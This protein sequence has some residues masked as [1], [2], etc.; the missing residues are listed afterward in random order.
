L[1]KM[2]ER[3]GEDYIILVRLHVIVKNT[4]KISRELRGFVKNVSN[5]PDMQDLLLISDVLI[6]DYSSSMF[7][8]ANT[9][10]PML[11]YTYDLEEYRDDIRGFRSEEHTSELQ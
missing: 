9:K 3:L 7:D 5:Y 10:K 6:T 2:Q 1:E 11:F 8:F 4:L